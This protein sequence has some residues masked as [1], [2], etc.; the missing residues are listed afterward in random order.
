MMASPLRYPSTTKLLC[1]LEVVFRAFMIKENFV[2]H[3]KAIIAAATALLSVSV[4]AS[5]YQFVQKIPG[6]KYDPC[7]ALE[8]ANEGVETNGMYRL[9]HLR[10]T[11]EFKERVAWVDG[12]AFNLEKVI[13]LEAF[14]CPDGSRV[15]SYYEG[16]EIARMTGEFVYTT[17]NSALPTGYSTGALG[18]QGRAHYVDASGDATERAVMY[19]NPGYRTSKAT[20]CFYRAG[21]H[22]ALGTKNCGSGNSTVYMG[23]N[24][25]N[26]DMP[27]LRACMA[28]P[29]P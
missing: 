28:I 19:L 27:A 18:A 9:C 26:Q 16:Q 10:G 17:L 11:D 23:H 3:A 7:I 13:P 4:S 8:G 1:N 6:M 24:S 15:A 5:E 20:S 29:I 14:T 2:R 25:P 12:A 22:Y 21:D